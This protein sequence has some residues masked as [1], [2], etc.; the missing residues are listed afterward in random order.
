M[1]TLQETLWQDIPRKQSE[2]RAR[3]GE[4]RAKAETPE[5]MAERT[6]LEARQTELEG[7]YQQAHDAVKV[8]Q[9]Q[10]LTDDAEARALRQLTGRAN[11]GDVFSAL[12]EKRA[13]DGATKEMQDHF[14]V[15]PHSIPLDMLR[16][17]HRAIT[18][19]PTNTG[20]DEQPVVEPV[21][22]MGDAAFLGVD[23][24]TIP[25]GDAVFPVLTTRPTVGGP[26]TDSTSVSETTGAFTA[27]A[28]PPGRLQASFFY[29]RS[30]AARFAGMSESCGRLSTWGFPRA[31]TKK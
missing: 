19:G 31:W 26:H 11:L 6:T 29:L 28:L 18:P 27:A 25:S 2:V 17:E 24:V 1:T 8:E 9:S 21:F 3:L 14:K 15:G 4:I 20:A 10:N 7:E 23:Q 30:D 13:T 22:S 12:I 5:L 16:E